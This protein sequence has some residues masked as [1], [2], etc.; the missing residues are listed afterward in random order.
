MI[1]SF[2]FPL[3]RSPISDY[4]AA[5]GF[6]G[7]ISDFLSGPVRQYPR[8]DPLANYLKGNENPYERT[9]YE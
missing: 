1:R 7:L 9:Y 5:Q 6:P 8:K 3:D 4:N 2:Y